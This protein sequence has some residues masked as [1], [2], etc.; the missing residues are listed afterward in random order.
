[1]MPSMTFWIIAILWSHSDRAYDP[2]DETIPIIF[3]HH[4]AKLLIYVPTGQAARCGYGLE[5][6]VYY[7]LVSSH[8]ER[9]VSENECR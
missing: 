1:M 3:Q 7:C 8:E 9:R 6:H 2:E 5:V 4:Q